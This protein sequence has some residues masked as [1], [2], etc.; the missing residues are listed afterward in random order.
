MSHVL[1]FLNFRKKRMVLRRWEK[2]W[3]FLGD[4]IVLYYDL[5]GNYIGVLIL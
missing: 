3:E 1:T 5:I 2:A 4:D